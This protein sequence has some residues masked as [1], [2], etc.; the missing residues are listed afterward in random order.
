MTPKE[1]KNRFKIRCLECNVEMDFDYKTKHNLKY[2]QLLLN[3]R[4]IIPFSVFGAPKNPF[5]AAT[6]KLSKIELSTERL[7][8]T[9]LCV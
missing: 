9:S 6:G 4:K 5:E 3:K 8:T 7:Q 1:R 2:H